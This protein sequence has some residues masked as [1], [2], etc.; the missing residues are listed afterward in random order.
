MPAVH[1]SRCKSAAM[2]AVVRALLSDM[3]QS[4]DPM[5]RPICTCRTVLLKLPRMD[6]F[7]KG[8]R[9]SEQQVRRCIYKHGV[10]EED[11]VSVTL[12]HELPYEFR[13]RRTYRGAVTGRSGCHRDM[14]QR[15]R[16]HELVQWQERL[17]G[18]FKAHGELQQVSMPGIS[19][20]SGQATALIRCLLVG[21]YLQHY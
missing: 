18:M 1:N 15:D 3:C 4:T 5:P 21:W 17:Q 16:E 14:Q 12:Q 20:T 2:C 8:R 9:L 11:I 19:A 6:R 7:R 13:S 10:A